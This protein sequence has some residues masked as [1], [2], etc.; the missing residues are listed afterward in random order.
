MR[1]HR[2]WAESPNPAFNSAVKALGW[3]HEGTKRQTFLLDGQL[4]DVECWGLLKHEF[5]AGVG[6]QQ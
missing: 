5:N 3:S 4:V 6:A 1:L 2:I